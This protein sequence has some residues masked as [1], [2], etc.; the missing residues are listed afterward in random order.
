VTLILFYVAF[1]IGGDLVAYLAGLLVEYEF[2][3][4]VSLIAFLALY[5]LFSLGLLGARSLGN[6]TERCRIKREM[7]AP[8]PKR[9]GS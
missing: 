5:F 3:S 4:H 1:M 2:G 7:K 9:C 8:R 6:Y